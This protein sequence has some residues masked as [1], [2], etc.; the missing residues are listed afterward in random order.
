MTII[1]I[2]NLYM[3]R[4]ILS[5]LGVEDYGIFNVVA[6]V[7]T[8]MQSFSTTLS[9][10]TQRYFSFFLGTN[11][12]EKLSVVFS[13]SIK[14]YAYFC[15]IVFIIGETLG[16]WFVNTQLVIPTERIVAANVVYQFSILSFILTMITATYCSAVIS[17]ENM[18]LY[19][20]VSLT[21]CFLKLLFALLIAH[22]PFDRLCFYSGSLAMVSL[23]SLLIYILYSRYNYPECRK[24]VKTNTYTKEML[25]FSGWTLFGSLASISMY[26]INTILVNIFFG[27]IVNAARAISMQVNTAI[28][29][30][31]SSFLTTVKPPIIKTYADGNYDQ[32]NFIF[33]ISNKLILYLLG[34]LSMP[35][36]FEMNGIL[37][38]WLD[39]N[40]SQTVIFSQLMVVYA[41]I[42][43]LNNPISFII[44]ATGCVK[45]YNIK[46]EVFTILCMPATYLAFK[47]GAP[48]E[49]TF[50]LMIVAV[51]CSH[52]VRLVILKKYYPLFSYKE[53]TLGFLLP[54]VM[55]LS[56]EFVLLWFLHDII[57]CPLIIKILIMLLIVIVL[58]FPIIYHVGLNNYE[59]T[60]INSY[61]KRLKLKC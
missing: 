51:V 55:V 54:A 41:I 21:E 17:H 46:V 15:L 56:I 19:A 24:Y 53:Y 31:T 30:F 9:A 25:S 20:I 8:L 39:K 35:I 5:S 40:D 27:P 11:E 23:V 50:I 60:V 14:L 44:Q 16:L 10:S 28:N 38:W 42:L 13:T 36:I 61:F 1:M 6:G 29:S 12:T 48:A 59:K 3:V 7:V 4:V 52:I 26:Q 34:V 22:Q 32:L 37:E 43:A 45:E 47:F 33:G 57:N 58:A 2:V 49:A 18:G